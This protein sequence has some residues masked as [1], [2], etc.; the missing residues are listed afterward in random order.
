MD[1]YGTTWL[2]HAPK[3]KLRR[4]DHKEEP[5]PLSREEQHR[6]FNELPPY[7]SKI[8]LFKIN[9]GCRGQEVCN[10]RWE[11]EVQVP[12][13]NPSVFIVPRKMVKNR[14][15]RL[16]GLNRLAK[17]AVEEMRG[18]HPTRGS[19]EEATRMPND[20]KT[21]RPFSRARP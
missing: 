5:Y 17:E 6:L 19:T 3:I 2:A 16:V 9:T 10:L 18:V 12:E 8:A 14:E 7:L 20:A 1:E 4:E 13:L 15:E 21:C 11:W